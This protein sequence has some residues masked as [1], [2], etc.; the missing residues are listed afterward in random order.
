M[1]Q[2]N[3]DSFTDLIYLT[4]ESHLSKLAADGV[5]VPIGRELIDLMAPEFLADSHVASLR[6]DGGT[7]YLV[8]ADERDPADSVGTSVDELPTELRWAIAGSTPK[9]IACGAKEASE[10][11]DESEVDY[12]KIQQFDEGCT[13][14]YHCLLKERHAR[15]LTEIKQAAK[16]S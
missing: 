16:E 1:V 5:E 15:Q 4:A 13:L 11:G 12:A 6:Y 8:V 2:T 7:I 14:L 9:L 10:R 3:R